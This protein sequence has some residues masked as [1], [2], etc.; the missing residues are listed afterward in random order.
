VLTALWRALLQCLHWRVL[1]GALLPLLLVGSAVFVLGYV[2]W[3]DAVAG[4]RQTLEQADLLGDFLH[5]LDKL[6]L[7]HLRALLGP[8]VVVALAVPLVLLATLLVV[9]VGVTPVVVRLVATRRFAG[10]HAARGASWARCGVWSLLCAGAA[11]LA[12]VLSL[13]LWLVP[14]LVAVVPPLIGGWLASRVLAFAALAHHASA[15]ERRLLLRTRRWPLL[16]MGLVCGVLG[17]L[18]A[19][20]WTRGPAALI[21]APL[22]APVV[23]WLYTVVFVFAACWFAHYLLAELQALRASGSMQASVNFSEAQK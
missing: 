10:L 17:G 16:G 8:L 21:A 20:V 19:G 1:L 5:W 13:P 15:D 6:G 2:F 14:P 7:Q 9:A 18:P 3:E 11:L 23:V 12:L 4:V 22:L